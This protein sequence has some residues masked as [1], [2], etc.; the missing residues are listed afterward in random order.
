MKSETYI[1]PQLFEIGFG[2]VVVV[3]EKGGGRCEAG[4]FLLDVFCRGACDGAFFRMTREE[5]E[6]LLLPKLFQDQAPQRRSGPYGRKL[7]EEA[8]AYARSL[9][10]PPCK[11]YKKG[12]RVFGGINPA[13][14]GETFVFGKDGRPFYLQGP[15]DKPETAERIIRLLEV[16]CGVDGFEYALIGPFDEFDEFDD[17]EEILET[18]FMAMESH[19][20]SQD[21]ESRNSPEL[22]EF[23]RGFIEARDCPVGFLGGGPNSPADFFHKLIGEC[24]KLAGPPPTPEEYEEVAR[25]LATLWNLSVL[26]A[27][28]RQ[29]LLES[30]SKKQRAMIKDTDPAMF[31]TLQEP[32]CERGLRLL[33][34]DIKLVKTD[35]AGS[36]VPYNLLMIVEN[37]DSD[38]SSDLP[39][40]E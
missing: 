14:C 21:E 25:C 16:H 3:R 38:G 35:R 34:E 33:I 27:E 9:G 4:T 20:L 5:L 23:T 19:P 29:A 24:V 37:I 8:V 10:I 26:P 13:E 1:T 11:D 15:S 2:S 30:L 36:G 12:A 32:L 18:P 40:L 17:D 6:S 28:E 7:V 31:E 22:V 39:P